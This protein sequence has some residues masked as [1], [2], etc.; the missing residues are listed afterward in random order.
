MKDHLADF[1]KPGFIVV[2]PQ[3]FPGNVG[4][5]KS[6]NHSTRRF[7]AAV[8]VNAAEDRLESAREYRSLGTTATQ[9][10]ALA[11]AQQRTKTELSRLF[12]KNCRVDQ[13]RAH[14][15]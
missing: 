12:G 8:L 6:F 5:E 10:L 11:N 1:L 13:S 14:L 15:G 4:G 3:R 9:F 2:L 7:V